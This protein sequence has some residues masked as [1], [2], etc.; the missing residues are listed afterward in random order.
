MPMNLMD[1][2]CGKA[3]SWYKAAAESAANQITLREA[4][5]EVT[6]QGP[7]TL[8]VA[9]SAENVMSPTYGGADAKRVLSAVHDYDVEIPA[10]HTLT[11]KMAAFAAGRA[12]DLGYVVNL[13]YTSC[14]R[15]PTVQPTDD[16][17]CD[18]AVGD[19]P[20]AGDFFPAGCEPCGTGP[21]RMPPSCGPS[22]ASPPAPGGACGRGSTTACSSPARTWRPNSATSGSST[23]SRTA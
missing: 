23:S 4:D 5:D 22:L 11:Y 3:G 17:P 12:T 8:N 21:V 10:G 14:G 6:L 20:G 15:K 2:V 7:L 16:V 19:L 9:L 1:C 18:F 13:R